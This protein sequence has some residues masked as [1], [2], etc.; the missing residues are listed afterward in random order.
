MDAVLEQTIDQYS[1]TATPSI[2]LFSKTGM[3]N[4][5]HTIKVVV[6]NEKHPNAVNSYVVIDAFE[7]AI[8]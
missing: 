4:T 8:N 7:Y 3:P 1:L 5:Q 6:K 2:Q